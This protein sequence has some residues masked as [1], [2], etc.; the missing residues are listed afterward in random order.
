MGIM[1]IGGYSVI[2]LCSLPAYYLMITYGIN[3]LWT[4]FPC[5]F[6][7]LPKGFDLYIELLDKTNIKKNWYKGCE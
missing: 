2:L 6:L 7:F 3:Y 5:W 1:M 4:V